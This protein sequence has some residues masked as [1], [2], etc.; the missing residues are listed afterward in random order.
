[1][2]ATKNT[3]AV[4]LEYWNQ[5]A[6]QLIASKQLS[7]EQY[8]EL[9]NAAGDAVKLG[10]S[11]KTIAASIGSGFIFDRSKI[12]KLYYYVSLPFYDHKVFKCA[13]F[14]AE[15]EQHRAF[16]VPWFEQNGQPNTT[17]RA[18]Y[19]AKGPFEVAILDQAIG[20]LITRDA[21]GKWIV[22]SAD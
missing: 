22:Y 21:D 20:N 13:G 3:P 10:E 1:M 9:Q 18:G 4:T 17:D 2:N 5:F 15:D 8:A 14:G 11:V 6:D 12:S 19:A 16:Y 7:F